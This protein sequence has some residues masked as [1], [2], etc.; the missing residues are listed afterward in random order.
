[1]SIRRI[2]PGI[3]LFLAVVVLFSGCPG[4]LGPLFSRSVSVTGTLPVADVSRSVRSTDTSEADTVIALPMTGDAIHIE[5]VR[6]AKTAPVNP[7]GTFEID[8]SSYY[9]AWLLMAVDSDAAGY[10][11]IVGFMTIAGDDGRLNT[12]PTDNTSGD[13]DLGDLLLDADTS[14]FIAEFSLDSYSAQFNLS[15]SELRALSRIDSMAKLMANL[16]V[17]DKGSDY[18]SPMTVY[19]FSGSYTDAMD[20][21]APAENLT[22]STLYS[23]ITW[24]N[25]PHTIE[26]VAAGQVL[27]QVYPPSEIA[28]NG[29]TADPANPFS[30]TGTLQREDREDGSVFLSFQGGLLAVQQGRG[31]ISLDFNSWD[32]SITA[33]IPGVW[34]VYVDGQ[35]TAWV[36][37]RAGSPYD[38]EGN[39][40][41]FLPEPRILFDQEGAFSRLDV[42]FKQHDGSSLV[43][44][45]AEALD[46]LQFGQLQLI[47]DDVNTYDRKDNAD[48][49]DFVWSASDGGFSHL[50]HRDANPPS[51]YE[52]LCQIGVALRVYGEDLFFEYR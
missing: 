44:A 41:V 18:W 14:E 37:F 23:R 31:E 51:G 49:Q 28:C 12:I 50:W 13:I 26:D 7:D 15:P 9:D 3:I 17:S 42:A 46:F 24:E 19:I 30:N 35:P 48:E 20:T 5:D 32:D 11:K 10:D 38:A 47:G 33:P 34:T 43:S 39:L 2:L 45:D 22:F 52:Y 8:L 29:F 27:I 40:I 25:P 21:P 36:D 6:Q 16:W 4:I 1:M